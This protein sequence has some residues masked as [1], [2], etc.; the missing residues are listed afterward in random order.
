MRA[1]ADNEWLTERFEEQRTH[2]QAVAYRMLGSLAEAD[3]AVQEAWM[4]LNRSNPGE[5]ENL[6]GWLTT[7]VARVSLNMLRSRRVRR[8][9]AL[10]VHVPEPI[11]DPAEGTDPEHEALLA[12]L[13]PGR[14]RTVEGAPAVAGQALSY[15]RLAPFARPALVNGTMGIVGVRD[16]E[17]ISVL[18]FTFRGGKI[19]TVDILADP[20]RLRELDVS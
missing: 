10:G 12:D 1:M 17:P 5:I 18:G 20:A 7:V 6:S 11:V 16:G 14:S 2:L 3:D 15:A 4:R 8:E 9:D 13:G 19:A